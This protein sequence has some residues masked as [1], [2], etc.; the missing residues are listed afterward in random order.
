MDPILFWNDRHVYLA[1]DDFNFTELNIPNGS[2]L[3]E[4]T[5][6]DAE[7]FSFSK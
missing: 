5:D 7:V 1:E 2:L 4:D 6:D 3:A